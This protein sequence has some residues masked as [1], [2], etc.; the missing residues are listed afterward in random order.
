MWHVW[1]L[2]L[3]PDVECFGLVVL[4]YSVRWQLTQ[5]VGLVSYT[6]SAWQ[7]MHFAVAWFPLSGNDV[8]V[9]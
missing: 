9:L 5:V 3:K 8:W 4:L 6:L 1:Q 7:S 2:V